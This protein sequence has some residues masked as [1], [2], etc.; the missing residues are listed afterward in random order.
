M[1][2]W[3][4]KSGRFEVSEELA[5][6]FGREAETIRN[7]PEQLL[8]HLHADDLDRIK[9]P[10]GQ[11]RRGE[12]KDHNDEVRIRHPDGTIRW[13][14]VRLLSEAK[15][16]QPPALIV[17][18]VMD[19]TPTKRTQLALEKQKRQL[20]LLEAISGIGRWV[21]D[22]QTSEITW[23]RFIYEIHGVKPSEYRPDL[24]SA[25]DFYHPDDRERVQEALNRSIAD[26]KPFAFRLRIV[27]P[28]GTIRTVLSK[29]EPQVGAGGEVT[30]IFGVFQDV[31]AEAQIV[32]SA[33]A[34]DQSA[35][36]S[37]KVIYT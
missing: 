6:L 3:E 10:L 13:A 4:A 14:T 31:T 1:F 8:A 15:S 28:D 17:G 27:R 33:G 21:L 9:E 16:G 19:I 26:L 34:D 5:S 18:T 25:V 24:V 30:A 7:E 22:L 23:S 32:E 11:L 20:E 36:S 29:G 2:F 37:N 12:L 35:D